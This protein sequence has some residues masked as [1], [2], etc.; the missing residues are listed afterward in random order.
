MSFNVCMLNVSDYRS[1][2][3]LTTQLGESKNSSLLCLIN[4]TYICLKCI[5]IIKVQYVT[6]WRDMV[7]I[8][9]GNMFIKINQLFHSCFRVIQSTKYTLHCFATKHTYKKRNSMQREVLIWCRVGWVRPSHFVSKFIHLHQLANE[10]DKALFAERC[11]KEQVS[12]HKSH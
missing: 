8:Y 6:C 5:T 12:N 9:V 11:C 10:T 7:Q 4:V 2:F 1:F 3:N